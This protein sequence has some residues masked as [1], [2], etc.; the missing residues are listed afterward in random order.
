V[1]C[2]D[3]RCNRP[4][5]S[6]KPYQRRLIVKQSLDLTHRFIDR[7]QNIL[8]G[9]VPHPGERICII[10]GLKFWPF[11]NL[12]FNLPAERQCHDKNIGEEDC[13]IKSKPADWLQRYFRGQ[14]WI[15][16]KIEKPPGL[17]ASRTIFGKIPSCLPHQPDRRDRFVLAF[18]HAQKFFP[19]GT[20]DPSLIHQES[21]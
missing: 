5:S 21:S 6:T 16:A 19:H 17:F 3:I 13:G 14:L 8:I 20:V 1:S 10:Q 4:R 12:K 15:K 7:R 2:H 18:Q 9:Y 11:T